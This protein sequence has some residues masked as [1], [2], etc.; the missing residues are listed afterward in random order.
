MGL[1]AV[2]EREGDYETALEDYLKVAEEGT[3]QLYIVTAMKHIGTMYQYGDVY[4]VEQDGAK[5]IEWYT[6]AAD[7]G[8][9]D[10]MNFMGAMYHNGD[11]VEQDFGVAMEWLQ[12]AADLG[13]AQAMANIAFMY[14]CGNGVA[15]DGAQAIEWYTKAAD[16]GVLSA[17]SEIGDMYRNG[18]GVEQ[19]DDKALEWYVK[20]LSSI[21]DYMVYEEI[22]DILH[23]EDAAEEW[24]EESGDAEKMMALAELYRSH[25]YVGEEQLLPDFDKAIEW[26]TKAADLGNSDAMKM[27]G[28][29]YEYAN[30]FY[31]AEQDLDKAMEW[32]QKAAD[33]GN[34]EAQASLELLQERS[35]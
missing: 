24:F 31:E 11:G 25:Y 29:M 33:L 3:E 26:Y 34:E 20:S 28:Y 22:V 17:L 19:D 32:Y 16:L 12:K 14:R 8:N 13:H 4:G 1:A 10:A 15:Q 5:A 27:I 2:A 30:I 6:K 9:S 7:L 21:P 23:G 35:Y 18:E